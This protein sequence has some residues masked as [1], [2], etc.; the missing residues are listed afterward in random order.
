MEFVYKFIANLQNMFLGT[1]N[2]LNYR[3]KLFACMI[4]VLK[5]NKLEYE[6]ILKE[7]SKEI[8]RKKLQREI[9]LATV[10]DYIFIAKSDILGVDKL[11]KDILKTTKQNPK[12]KNKINFVQLNKLIIRKNL[13]EGEGEIEDYAQIRV[14]E[15]LKNEVIK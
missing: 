5:D 15:F 6:N 9:F 3:A 12:Y 10:K 11:L 13:K 2:S 14:L 7:V 8:Y 1:N 4:A